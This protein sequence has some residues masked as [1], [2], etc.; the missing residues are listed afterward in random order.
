VATRGKSRAKKQLAKSGAEVARRDGVAVKPLDPAKLL[1]QARREIANSYQQGVRDTISTLRT[2]DWL[3]PQQPTPPQAPADAAEIRTW[4]Y[5]TGYNVSFQPRKYAPYS[6]GQLRWV[7]D[8]FDLLREVIER[9]KDEITSLDWDV[10]SRDGDNIDDDD[11]AQAIIEFLRYPDGN[12]QHPF[13]TWQRML[14][15]DMFV[16]DAAAIY[17]WP[18]AS[19]ELY[20]LEVIDGAIIVPLI[21]ES[22]R[23]PEPPEPAFQQVIKGLPYRNLEGAGMATGVVSDTTTIALTSQELIYFPRNTRPYMPMYGYS[24]VEQVVLTIA[25][26]IKAELR[27]YYWFT[28][29]TIPDSMISVPPNWTGKQ[30]ARF[31]AWFDDM[32]RGN[33]SRRSGGAVFV[34]GGVKDVMLKDYKFDL[35]MFQWIARVVC[36]SFHVSNQPYIEQQNRATAQTAQVMQIAEAEE[37]DKQWWKSL[38]NLVI[39]HYFGRLD[40]KFAY[41]ED[42]QTDPQERA[43]AADIQV[44]GG[45]KTVNEIRMANGDDP[46]PA[47]VGDKP[48]IVAG[49]MT[50]LL[51]DI[52]TASQKAVA[53][54]PVVA[55]AQ[56]GG[57]EAAAPRVKPADANGNAGN[58][59]GN[60]AT[61]KAASAEKKASRQCAG[62]NARRRAGGP[63]AR[64]SYERVF[65]R[66]KAPGR[67]RTGRSL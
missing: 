23:R 49:N 54:A 5:P 58:D 36:A 9:R 18:K 59:A 66:G 33:L 56:A 48:F 11:G 19:G 10:V 45:T 32:L 37:P 30:I 55:G 43:K 24:Q 27:Q 35:P 20:R 62:P 44:R 26:G 17:P 39:H 51:E 29:G 53:P 12:P 7:A 60:P 52:E 14:L 61:A 34:P 40:L 21:D 8:N 2:S 25:I 38:M 64:T 13:Q 67:G 50:V 28:E 57:N 63:R 3:G 65:Q 1:A 22:G 46:Y 41:K 6:F 16:I 47:G 42:D 31:Q 4:D 15:E